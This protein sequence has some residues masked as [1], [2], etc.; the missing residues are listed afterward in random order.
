MKRPP[1]PESDEIKNLLSWLR[2][3]HFP[4]SAKPVKWDWS[5]LQLLKNLDQRIR[6]LEAA[7]ES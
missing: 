2:D 6:R 7:D 4:T 1:V 5:V 3:T